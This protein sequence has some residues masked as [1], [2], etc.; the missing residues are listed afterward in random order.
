MK[1][2]VNSIIR[3]YP[4]AKISSEGVRSIE[5][6]MYY[7]KTRPGQY[8]KVLRKL[9]REFD[10]DINR[11]NDDSYLKTVYD[12]KDE[13]LKRAIKQI[14]KEGRGF[15]HVSGDAIDI[16]VGTLTLPMKQSLKAELEEEGFRVILERVLNGNAKYFVPITMANVFHVDRGK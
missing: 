6:Q 13:W 10:L 12:G 8:K 3:K 2:I 9:F 15:Y 16:T 4:S 1:S 11:F 5:K 7:V 14:S